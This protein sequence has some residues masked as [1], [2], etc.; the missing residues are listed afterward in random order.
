M[1][2]IGISAGVAALRGLGKPLLDRFHKVPSSGEF[3][4]VGERAI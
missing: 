1:A 4:D 2:A 3:E